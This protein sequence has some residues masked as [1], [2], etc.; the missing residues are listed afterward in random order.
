MNKWTN[1]RKNK[2]NEKDMK[3]QLHK[4]VTG[5]GTIGSISSE[6][7][8]Q[9]PATSLNKSAL[10][11]FSSVCSDEYIIQMLSTGPSFVGLE[12]SL[13]RWWTAMA[14]SRCFNPG[15]NCLSSLRPSGEVYVWRVCVCVWPF[16]KLIRRLM[17]MVTIRLSLPT[18]NI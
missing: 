5:H 3:A 10:L 14:S 15:Q 2:T 4:R 6:S 7:T 16:V 17:N 8:D 18:T 9:K 1:D 11:R 12:F 13:W